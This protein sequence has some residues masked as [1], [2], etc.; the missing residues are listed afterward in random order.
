MN[1]L[2]VLEL[3]R[4][5]HAATRSNAAAMSVLN[6]FLGTRARRV[7][8]SPSAVGGIALSRLPG[9]HQCR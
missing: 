6:G 7:T 3:H 5:Q 9:G 1:E 2:D 4:G 8:V